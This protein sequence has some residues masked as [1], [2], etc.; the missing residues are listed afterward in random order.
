MANLQ[1]LAA[2]LSEI[3]DGEMK[4]VSA[5]E[6]KV[7]LVRVGDNC[8]AVGAN[9]THYGAP[10]VDGALVGDRI[11]CPWHHACFRASTGALLEPPALDALPSYPVEIRGDDI[12]IE[13]P[14]EP[15]DRRTPEMTKADT[16]AD[17]RV[18][19]II[20]GGAA[21]Y[22]AAQTLRE[23]DFSG[24]ILMVTREDRTPYDRPNLSKDYLQ[25]HAEPEWM[26][27]RSDEF[28][29]EHNIELLRG[30]EATAL[31]TAAKELKLDDGSTLGYD[32]LLLAPGGAPRRLSLPKSD[33]ANIF[34]LRS[35]D[36]ADA[37]AAAAESAK[38]AVII[39]ASF[40]GM[41]AASSLK[42]RGLS[43]T[44]VAPDRVPF[45]KTLGPEIGKMLQSLHEYNGV[46]FRLGG[47]AIAFEG[48]ERVESVV[49]DSD[50]RL[51]ADLVIVGIGVVP[52]T[53]FLEGINLEKDGGVR[54]D[55]YFRLSDDV[56]AAGDI[57]HFP[58]AHTGEFIRIEHWRTAL[59]QGRVA[60]HNMAGKPTAFTAVPF[61]WT[62]QFDAT[63]AYVGQAKFWDE[64]IFQGDV[65]Q[66]EFLAF[67]IKDRQVLAV[68]GMNR[69][70]E[71]AELQELMRLDKVPYPAK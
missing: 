20:G 16:N 35:F 50:E 65:S 42:Q 8:H 32:S 2:K 46:K 67:Y 38:N 54:T 33:L 40:I 64:V 5:G 43:V 12:F 7:L 57:V 69:D 47:H 1:T 13:M 37:I 41:E 60:A 55:E 31:D 56:Y 28:F 36:D 17:K 15:T 44:V 24:R 71:M 30:R 19:V 68:A 9:C 51:D 22:A 39:G 25:G 14:A 70:R 27:L 53:G 58:A 49:L 61:F 29:E 4:E 45:E 6:T 48:S 18:F 62:T 26:P 10:L 21:G 34:V 52:A 11:I 23:D 66:Q 63:L 59:Q 3:G